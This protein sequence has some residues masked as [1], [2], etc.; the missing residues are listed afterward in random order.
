M[1][2]RTIDTLAWVIGYE[3]A[4]CSACSTVDAVR[5]RKAMSS[6]S[7]LV[8]ANFLVARCIWRNPQCRRGLRRNFWSPINRPSMHVSDHWQKPSIWTF[9]ARSNVIVDEMDAENEVCVR[10]SCH[11]HHYTRMTSATYVTFLSY[12]QLFKPEVD[13]ISES[14]IDPL[15][16]VHWSRSQPLST[17]RI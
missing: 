8:R 6:P 3:M 9:A 14:A 2:L 16:S 5:F 4:L 11:D 13:L 1:P 10:T 7:V 17:W 12:F 15:V